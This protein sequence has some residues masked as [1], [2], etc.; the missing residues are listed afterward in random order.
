VVAVGRA[1]HDVRRALKERGYAT[2]TP[3][4]VPPGQALKAEADGL[5]PAAERVV[6]EAY[7]L[8]A[9]GQEFRSPVRY[10][11]APETNDLKGLHGSRGLRELASELADTDVEPT[12]SGY[13]FYEDGDFIGLHTDLPACELTLLVA[14]GDD[15]PPLV[16][17]PE[18]A[19]MPAEEL[20]A[21][22]E[23]SHGAPAGGLALPIVPGSAVAL[24]GGGLPH[25]TR[26]IL[27]GRASVVATLCYAGV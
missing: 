17:H 26:P 14:V 9:D 11:F 21:L 22:S 18:L 4:V 6:K 19:G 10:G 13:L 20:K 27:Q 5:H 1:I 16:V 15:C 23:T 2:V 3:P 24:F 25:Q 8:W 7:E 12:Y